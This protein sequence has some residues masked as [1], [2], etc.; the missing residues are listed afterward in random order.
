MT[1]C[2]AIEYAF[3]VG[4]LKEGLFVGPIKKKG[5]GLFGETI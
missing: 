4:Y 2:C 1:I 5:L 3:N